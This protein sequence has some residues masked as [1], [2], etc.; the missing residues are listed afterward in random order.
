MWRVREPGRNQAD[1]EAQKIDPLAPALA[2]EVEE[3]S[4]GIVGSG[5]F[6][7]HF[8]QL[9]RVKTLAVLIV[10]QIFAYFVLGV[11]TAFLPTY[12]QQKDTYGFSS[13]LAGLYS[14]GVIVL[15]GIAGMLAFRKRRMDAGQSDAA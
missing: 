12:L 6:F 2:S 1:E 5:S 7:S 8:W 15:A 9:L 4:P 3:P 10:M 14:G 13:G 11:N